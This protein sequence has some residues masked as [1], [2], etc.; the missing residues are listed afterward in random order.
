MRSL[1]PPSGPSHPRTDGCAKGPSLLLRKLRVG[2]LSIPLVVGP[3]VAL[4]VALALFPA[5]LSPS[6]AAPLA[7]ATVTFGAAGDYGFSGDAQTTMT[8]MG[9]RASTS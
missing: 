4:L 9:R 1:N 3:I 7:G 2:G 5:A 6:A 8:H